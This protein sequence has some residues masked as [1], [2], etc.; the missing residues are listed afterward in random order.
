MMRWYTISFVEHGGM[1]LH[2]SPRR[3]LKTDITTDIEEK[4]GCGL[5]LSHLRGTLSHSWEHNNEPSVSVKC[6]EFLSF[7]VYLTTMSVTR[8]I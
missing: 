2:R 8:C 7:V 4:R 5:D 1:R 6:G 3:K